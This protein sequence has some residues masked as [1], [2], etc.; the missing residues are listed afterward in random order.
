MFG[1]EL[2]A[3]LLNVKYLVLQP[4]A[5]TMPDQRRTCG[6]RHASSVLAAGPFGERLAANDLPSIIDNSGRTA[7]GCK[8]FL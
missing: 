2:P 8:D 1:A 5:W 4:P 3:V 6:I 7:L